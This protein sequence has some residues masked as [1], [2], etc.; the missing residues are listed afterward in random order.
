MTERNS[1]PDKLTSVGNLKVRSE[2]LR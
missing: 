2:L 1:E